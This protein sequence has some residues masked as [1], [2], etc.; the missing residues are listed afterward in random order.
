MPINIA[1]VKLQVIANSTGTFAEPLTA[2]FNP[3]PYLPLSPQVAAVLSATSQAGDTLAGITPVP[4][5]GFLTPLTV[6]SGM[7]VT[8]YSIKNSDSSL[9]IWLKF[10]LAPSATAGTDPLQVFPTMLMPLLGGGVMTLSTP[11]NPNSLYF[12][13]PTIGMSVDCLVIGT[14]AS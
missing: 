10:S 8:S 5:M 2:A 1:Q 11:L 6:P 13:T 12:Y 14:Y 4:G 7:T 3:M 9:T